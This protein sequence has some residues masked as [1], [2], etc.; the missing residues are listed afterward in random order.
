MKRVFFIALLVFA[1]NQA[2]AQIGVSYLH[3][4]VISTIGASYHFNEKLWAEVKLG[5]SVTDV[6]PHGQVNYNLLIKEK[7]SLYGGAAL[8]YRYG[9]TTNISASNIS[10]T[11]GNSQVVTFMPG[12]GFNVNPFSDLPNFAI[13]AESLVGI[14]SYDTFIQGSIGIRYFLEKN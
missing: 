2:K 12:V 9:V 4:D 3:S 11:V 1:F 8:A 7:F 6:I 14:S 13:S 5:A 10:I